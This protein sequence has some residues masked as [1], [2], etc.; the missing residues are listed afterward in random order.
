ML[1]SVLDWGSVGL[2]ILDHIEEVDLWL[3]YMKDLEN[4]SDI[5]VTRFF[6][7]EDRGDLYYRDNNDLLGEIWGFEGIVY[8]SFQD[9]ISVFEA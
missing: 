5:L 6:D 2:R 9:S 4:P 8:L 7:L 3:G 1:R